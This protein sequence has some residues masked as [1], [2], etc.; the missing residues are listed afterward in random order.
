[1][2]SGPPAPRSSSAGAFSSD[3]LSSPGAGFLSP[4]SRGALLTA[5]LVMYLLLALGAGFAS[6]WLWGLIQR[7]YDGWSGVAWRVASYFPGITLATLSCL[8]ILLVHTGSSGA[9]PLTAFFSLI[10][11]WFIISIPLCFSGARP[12]LPAAPLHHACDYLQPTL[13]L[14]YMSPAS[15]LPS[16]VPHSSYTKTF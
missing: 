6:V 15:A 7:S 8:N 4:A 16:I 12:S 2:S 10:S 9:I 14:L 1:M 11:L 5:M 3:L 13:C